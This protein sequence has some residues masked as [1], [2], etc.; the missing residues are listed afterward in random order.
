MAYPIPS[1]SVEAYFTELIP[2]TSPFAFKRAPP[3]FPGFMAASVWIRLLFVIV[4]PVVSSV[5]ETERSRAEITP[6]VT[7][8]PYP[9]ALP[10]AI[11]ALPT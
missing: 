8:C 9:R 1:T 10:I 7:D 4:C 2:I 11:A 5:V 3:E 6:V